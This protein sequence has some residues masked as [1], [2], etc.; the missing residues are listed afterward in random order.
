MW[1]HTVTISLD[2]RVIDQKDFDNRMTAE[3]Y[4]AKRER[5]LRNVNACDKV[6]VT[7][8]QVS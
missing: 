1:K 8:V 4:A 5:E 3:E 2:G 7:P 6:D